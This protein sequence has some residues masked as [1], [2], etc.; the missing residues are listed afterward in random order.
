MIVP[1]YKSV[2]PCQE[3]AVPHMIRFLEIYTIM[4]PSAINR[5][6]MPLYWNNDKNSVTHLFSLPSM[7]V[8]CVLVKIFSC[9]DRREILR[10]FILYI[11]FCV[12]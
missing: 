7:W 10:G 4:Q 11:L 1:V 9:L 12:N 3:Q 8:G 6:G 2:S 5:K